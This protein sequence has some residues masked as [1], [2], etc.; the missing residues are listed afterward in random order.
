MCWHIQVDISAICFLLQKQEPERDFASQQL[1]ALRFACRAGDGV[2]R[3]TVW[4]VSCNPHN[5]RASA[6]CERYMYTEGIWL[7]VKT[8][9]SE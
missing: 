9:V 1:E 3:N 5:T 2:A 7:L 4:E 8:G 6:I